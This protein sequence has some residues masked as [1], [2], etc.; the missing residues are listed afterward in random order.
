MFLVLS[1]LFQ[2]TEPFFLF[3][4]RNKDLGMPPRKQQPVYH[5]PVYEQPREEPWN[6][7]EPDQK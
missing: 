7:T 5:D 3:L 6:R 4:N 1:I 2:V